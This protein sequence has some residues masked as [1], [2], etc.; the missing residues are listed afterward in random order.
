[1]ERK[2]Q[3]FTNMCMTLLCFS[4]NCYAKQKSMLNHSSF[5]ASKCSQFTQHWQVNHK[6]NFGT[7]PRAI[8]SEAEIEMDILVV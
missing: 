5:I 1:M 8:E 2:L 4:Q 6:V 3:C 7:C